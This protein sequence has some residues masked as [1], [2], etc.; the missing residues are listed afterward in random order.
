MVNHIKSKSKNMFQNLTGEDEK[1]EEKAIRKHSV[2]YIIKALQYNENTIQ[3]KAFDDEQIIT[4]KKEFNII[5]SF[6]NFNLLLF[7]NIEDESVKEFIDEYLEF[8]NV[9]NLDPIIKKLKS[10]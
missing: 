2:K 5:H 9:I 7:N 10:K 1:N 4:S 3:C 6:N 8:T